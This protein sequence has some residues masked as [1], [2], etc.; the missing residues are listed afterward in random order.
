[1]NY[2]KNMELEKA[3]ALMN[4]LEYTDNKKIYRKGIKN[5][6]AEAFNDLND[7][8]GIPRKQETPVIL[9]VAGVLIIVWILAFVFL[10]RTIKIKKDFEEALVE[11]EERFNFAMTA[12]TDGLWDWNI[13]TN[14]NYCSPR[15]MS[16]VGYGPKE[17]PHNIEVWESLLQE[18]D[19][20]YA[21]A[22]AQK[23]LAKNPEDQNYEAEFRLR[24]K[25]GGIDG[26]WR[27]ERSLLGIPIIARYVR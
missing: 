20:E 10:R 6:Q 25:K 1:M 19:K 11:S 4:D 15:W 12:S 24:H 3:T 16:M 21:I 9:V 23:I 18:E 7:R 13:K 14:T 17:L 27:E 26:F 8:M 2:A 22:K 5:F